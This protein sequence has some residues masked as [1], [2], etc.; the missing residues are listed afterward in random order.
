[1]RMLPLIAVAG[2]LSILFSACQQ[3][4]DLEAE[5]EALLQVDREFAAASAEFG[6]G[7]AFNRFLTDDAMQMPAG[8]NPVIGRTAI[9]EGMKEGVET[10]TLAWEPQDGAVSNSADLGWTWG[11]YTLSWKNEEGNLKKS[12]GKYLNV[13]KKVDGQWK[14]VVDI[15]NKSPAP[16]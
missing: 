4:F 14:V 9:Y 5:R 15:G 1:M 8:G 6:A 2:L 10:Y 13:W 16:E 12:Y 11:K 3:P 7:E